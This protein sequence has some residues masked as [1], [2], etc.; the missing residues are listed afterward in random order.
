MH[1]TKWRSTHFEISFQ[2]GSRLLLFESEIFLSHI[3]LFMITLGLACKMTNGAMA[4]AM[5]NKRENVADTGTGSRKSATHG[6]LV[7]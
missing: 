7:D 3:L 2:T 1:T 5:S 4:A 6:A